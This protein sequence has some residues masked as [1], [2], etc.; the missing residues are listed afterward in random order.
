MRWRDGGRLDARNEQLLLGALESY[1]RSIGLI[2]VM[3]EWRIR[4]TLERRESAVYEVEATLGPDEQVNCYVKTFRVPPDRPNMEIR[5]RNRVNRTAWL[6]D[7]VA[8]RERSRI[9]GVPQVL[10]SDS[11]LRTIVSCAVRGE[12]LGKVWSHLLPGRIRAARSTFQKLGRAIREIEEISTSVAPPSTY[13]D[14]RRVDSALATTLPHL[15]DGGSHWAEET[16]DSLHDRYASESSGSYWCHGDIN[17]SNVLID[18]GLVN[19]IDFDLSSRP[20]TFDLSAF[21]LR[22]EFERPAVSLWSDSVAGW[23]LEGY[24]EPDARTHPAFALVRLI[25]LSNSI[26]SASRRGDR[27]RLRRYA[28]SIQNTLSAVRDTSN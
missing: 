12:P 7:L 14:R 11:E 4:R 17:H 27:P 25:K 26:E 5:L 13:L 21:L 15:V 8:E 9:V 6:A 1:G 16:V 28:S 22:L 19:L 10:A 23:V 24:G 18:H 3:L 2:D 20:H